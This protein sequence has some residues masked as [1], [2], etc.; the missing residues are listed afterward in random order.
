MSCDDHGVNAMT[1]TMPAHPRRKL[2]RRM[3]RWSLAFLV[4]LK[5][6]LRSDS[7]LS[8]IKEVRQAACISSAFS[9]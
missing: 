3:L 5:A 1:A 9:L 8:E 6:G 2:A 4:T 7:S